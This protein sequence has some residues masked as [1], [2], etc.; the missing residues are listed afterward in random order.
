[1][2]LGKTLALHSVF[3]GTNCRYIGFEEKFLVFSTIK[4]DLKLVFLVF[5]SNLLLIGVVLTN[6]DFG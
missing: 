3:D 5:F 1:M 6:A 2:V 4:I